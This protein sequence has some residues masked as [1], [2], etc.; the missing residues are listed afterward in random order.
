MINLVIGIFYKS[1]EV[2]GSHILVK[3]STQKEKQNNA[4]SGSS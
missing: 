2:R 4:K 1:I 3:V